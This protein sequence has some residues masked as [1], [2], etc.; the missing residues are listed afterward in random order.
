[1]RV[2]AFGTD[3]GDWVSMAV[4]S[5]GSYGIEEGLVY[6][7]PVTV[8]DGQINIVKGL[9][10]NEFGLAR[11]RQNEVELKEERQAIKHLL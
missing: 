4:A 5:D 11:L 3:P 10:L 9:D 8:V 7:F 1:M 2:W 6:S